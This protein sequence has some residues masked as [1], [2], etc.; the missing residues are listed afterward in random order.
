MARI[1]ATKRIWGKTYRLA[2][3]CKYKDDAK[4]DAYDIK[5]HN[6]KVSTKI[7]KLNHGDD[8]Y[9]VYYHVRR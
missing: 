9:G 3:T 2:T 7:V 4:G 8:V 1:P 5:G 6:R